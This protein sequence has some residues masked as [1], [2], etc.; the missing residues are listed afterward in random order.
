ML[1]YLLSEVINS[2]IGVG[3][4]NQQALDS[5]VGSRACFFPLAKTYSWSILGKVMPVCF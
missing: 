1:N 4:E 5:F 3:F 2:L